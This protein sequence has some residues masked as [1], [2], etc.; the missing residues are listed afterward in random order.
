V[1]KDLIIEKYKRFVMPTYLHTKVVFVKG[2]GARVW[3]ID[4]EE[5]LDFFPGWAVSGLGH[6]HGRVVSAIK[7][8]AGKIIH[9]SNNYYNELQAELAEKIVQNSFEGKVFFANSG[10]EANECAIKLA[11][12][13]GNQ[14]KRYE[15]ITMEKS[16]HGRTLATLTA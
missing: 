4:G 10:A 9:V 16:F 12:R 14:A 5:Y 11:R 1:K 3:D 7:K 6:C 2:K 15:I 8:Q 13:Y